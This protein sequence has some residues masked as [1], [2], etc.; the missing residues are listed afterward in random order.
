MK[1]LHVILSL[2]LALL[3]Y[4]TVVIV[5]MYMGMWYHGGYTYYDGRPVGIGLAIGGAVVGLLF[6]WFVGC[7]FISRVVHGLTKRGT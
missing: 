1:V 6:S 4:I 3:G 2:F 5:L 7:P